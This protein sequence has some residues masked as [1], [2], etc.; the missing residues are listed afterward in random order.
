MHE[1][2]LMIEGTKILIV[3]RKRLLQRKTASDEIVIRWVCYPQ[4]C[5]IP[6]SGETVASISVKIIV[7]YKSASGGRWVGGDAL[8]SRL[9][10][11]S[12]PM[13]ATCRQL[14]SNCILIPVPYLHEHLP[15]VFPIPVSAAFDDEYLLAACRA[16]NGPCINKGSRDRTVFI[17]IDTDTY[18]LVHPLP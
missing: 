7:L 13:A 10:I 14:H 9:P 8:S 3:L 6:H 11:L 1:L 5:L 16:A 12:L 4:P 18:P 15:L 2:M 17:T